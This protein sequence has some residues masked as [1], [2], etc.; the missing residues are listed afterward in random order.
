MWAFVSFLATCFVVGA[1][2]RD[3]PASSIFLFGTLL[4]GIAVYGILIQPATIAR[5]HAEETHVNRDES[6]S[7]Y[8]GPYLALMGK[9]GE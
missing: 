4:T 7:M 8:S 1:P 3:N 2:T 5:L 6:E 9:Y